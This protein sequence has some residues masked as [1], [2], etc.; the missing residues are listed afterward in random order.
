MSEAAEAIEAGAAIVPL[1]IGHEKWPA[2]SDWTRFQ[3]PSRQIHDDWSV[4]K[5]REECTPFTYSFATPRDDK[6]VREQ[7]RFVKKLGTLRKKEAAEAKRRAKGK[8]S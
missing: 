4:A 8:K 7:E 6:D 2:P 3:R 1:R 5:P